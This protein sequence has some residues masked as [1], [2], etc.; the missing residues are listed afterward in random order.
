[1]RPADAG[2]VTDRTASLGDMLVHGTPSHALPHYP[3]PR[4]EALDVGV[5]VSEHRRQCCACWSRW[6][7]GRRCR[8]PAGF[9]ELGGGTAAP[10]LA[11]RACRKQPHASSRQGNIRILRPQHLELD[12]RRLPVRPQRLLMPALPAVNNPSVAVH[13][14]AATVG[15]AVPCHS[16]TQAHLVHP[17]LPVNAL[18]ETPRLHAH[19]SKSLQLPSCQPLAHPACATPALPPRSVALRRRRHQAPLPH[20]PYVSDVPPSDEMRSRLHVVNAC[21]EPLCRGVTLRRLWHEPPFEHTPYRRAR[22]ADESPPDEVRGRLHVVKHMMKA[23]LG[24]DH[25]DLCIPPPLGM[26]VSHMLVAKVTVIVLTRPAGPEAG[27]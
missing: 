18:E 10:R 20:M 5:I 21:T 14:S 19:A 3:A 26:V 27:G 17:I 25:A 9:L 11:C 24:L 4:S 13:R 16:K 15:V 1:M 2:R 8:P 12:L 6:T 22:G 7:D 23:Q